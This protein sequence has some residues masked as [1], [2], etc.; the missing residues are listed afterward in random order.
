MKNPTVTYQKLREATALSWKRDSSFTPII[1][2]ICSLGGAFDHQ[3]WHLS[4]AFEHNFGS[5][6]RNLNKPILK[7][8]NAEGLSGEGGGVEA[9]N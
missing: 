1:L 2:N 3:I 5:G 6:G 7:G 9:L 4:K 8:S